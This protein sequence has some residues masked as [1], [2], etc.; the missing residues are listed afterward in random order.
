MRFLKDF[1][2]WFFYISTAVL[3]IC[4]INFSV[5]DVDLIS[6]D[7]LWQI[8]LS[9]FL[10]A[11]V[12]VLLYPRENSAGSRIFLQC[13]IHYGA[14]CAVMILSGHQFG[15]LEYDFAGIA[16]MLVSVAV[17]YLICLGMYY[18][19]DR[20]NADKIN[21]RLREKYGENLSR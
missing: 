4:A 10:T 14:L 6:K 7:T 13:L 17:V 19:V 1:A 16:M 8:L 3:I 9:G 12:T 15:W 2:R 20:S 11:L 18:L 21:R 5:S